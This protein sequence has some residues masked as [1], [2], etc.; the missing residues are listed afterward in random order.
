MSE[1]EI[2]IP[3][4]VELDYLTLNATGEHVK[5]SFGDM[6]KRLFGKHKKTLESL[7]NVDMVLAFIAKTKDMK[8]KDKWVVT[9]TEFNLLE[10][11][12]K[13]S[14][15]DDNMTPCILPLLRAILAAKRLPEKKD[16][17]AVVA[18]AEPADDSKA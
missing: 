16:A 6:V 10:Q 11:M 9:Q 15:A 14:G 18:A 2:E 13:S 3:E 7:D 8:P 4:D 1:R 12:A 5:L 17:P